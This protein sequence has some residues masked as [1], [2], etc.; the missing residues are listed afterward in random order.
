MPYKC[1]IQP[2]GGI[3]HIIQRGNNK[4]SIF[5]EEI[6]K[7]YFIKLLKKYKPGLGYK[8]YSFVLMDNHYFVEEV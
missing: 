8:V 4:N 7:G 3:Y 6:D 2:I 5:R 1:R